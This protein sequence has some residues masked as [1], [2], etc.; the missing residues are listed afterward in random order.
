VIA[1]TSAYGAVAACGLAGGTEI[2]TTVFPFILR[3]VALLGIN[4]V[5]TP[6]PD[7]IRAWEKLARELPHDK[8]DSLTRVEPLSKIKELA[9]QILAGSIRGRVVLN[10]NA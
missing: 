1:A 4:S 10:V 9:E 8:L 6:K 3:N 5:N 2:N 7:R